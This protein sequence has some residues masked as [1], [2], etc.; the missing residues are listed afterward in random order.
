MVWS[1]R[2]T[3]NVVLALDADSAGQNAMIR[4]LES[5]PSTESE[6]VPVLGAGR[7]VQFERRLSVNIKVLAVPDGKDPDDFIRSHPEAWPETVSTASPYLQFYIQQIT[8]GVDLTDPRAKEAAVQR[9]ATLLSLLP[10]GVEMRHYVDLLAT[11]LRIADRDPIL[12]AIR[13]A[14]RG[15]SNNATPVTPVVRSA[16]RAAVEDYLV[17][18]ILTYPDVLSEFMK[19]IDP[20]DIVDSV[21]REI[22]T[23][24]VLKEIPRP[25]RPVYL[26]EREAALKAL[27]N[28]RVPMNRMEVITEATRALEKTRRDRIEYLVRE[29]RLNIADAERDADQEMLLMSLTALRDLNIQQT[30]MYPRKSP[31]FKDSRDQKA[32]KPNLPAARD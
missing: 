9:A 3:K 24:Q 7:L 32:A 10:D 17:G 20:D 23:E 21:N 26:T 14:R 18:L 25:G 19:S 2:L 13:L 6:D 12:E 31:V 15:R 16:Q 30:K 4:T 11:K 1:K 5:L 8:S 22:L 29:L 27:L 28:D